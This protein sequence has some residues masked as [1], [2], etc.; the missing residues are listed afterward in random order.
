MRHQNPKNLKDLMLDRDN[1][2]TQFVLVR[3]DSDWTYLGVSINAK[4]M[5]RP[6]N[7]DITIEL[8]EED[9]IK[10]TF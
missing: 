9:E 10:W 4:P 5:C 6:F 3:D 7:S 2:G 1:I 8:N